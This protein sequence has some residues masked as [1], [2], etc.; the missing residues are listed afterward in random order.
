MRQSQ[1]FIRTKRLPPKEAESISHKYLVQGDFVDCLMSGVFSLLPLGLR[2]H[3]KIE[4]IIREEMDAIGGQ[5]M[6]LPALQPKSLWMETGR[7]KTM[8]PP[9]FKL[10]DVHGK[11]I[12]LG[13]THEE[14]ITDIV[15]KR[16][17]SYKDLPFALYQIQNKFRNELRATGG[18]LRTREF[19]M[20]DLYSFHISFSD[21][22][23]YYNRVSKV[24]K[25]IFKRC[26]L[27]AIQVEASA[28]AIGGGE[29][30]EFMVLAETG[31][32]KIVMCQK[33]NWAANLEIGKKYKVCPKCK[34]RLVQKSSIE[35]GHLFKLGTEYSKKMKADFIDK[36]GKE[37]PI[38]MGCYGIGLGR[39]M[40]T[41]VEIHHD[42]KGII[43]PKNI[44]PFDIHLLCLQPT[45]KKVVQSAEKLYKTCQKNNIDILYDNRLASAGVKLN[46]ADL[47]GIPIRLVVSEK[48]VGKDAVEFKLRKEKKIELIK[49]NKIIQKIRS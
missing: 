17:K 7:W 24:Y 4:N 44:S 29:S 21:L 25:K 42:E 45:N 34:G 2:V 5:K 16:I 1:A 27:K 10:K 38:V 35:V 20:K 31:E 22:D 33:C 47:I 48:T 37:K 18:L 14:V 30:H 12:G 19:V 28:G 41:I 36:D 3:E 9:L 32:D 15:R 26:G 11:E 6:C 49:I 39:A 46:D 8:E 43:W 40:A 13:S 23:K